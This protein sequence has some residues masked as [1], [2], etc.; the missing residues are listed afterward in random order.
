MSETLE[1]LFTRR[2]KLVAELDFI[3]EAINERETEDGLAA[4][5]A[6]AEKLPGHSLGSVIDALVWHLVDAAH[7]LTP[8]FAERD[9]YVR[10][11]VDRAIAY[12]Q[13]KEREAAL[14]GGR[15]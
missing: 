14:N 9:K 8:D 13:H 11:A 7:Q 10:D 15:V 6:I 5:D 12:H 2:D 3:S 4:F 1:Q